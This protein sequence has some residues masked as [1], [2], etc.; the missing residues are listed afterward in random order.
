MYLK[1]TQ[2]FKA[3]YT[4]SYKYC[5]I[6]TG[7]N[8]KVLKTHELLNKILFSLSLSALF[9]VCLRFLRLPSGRVFSVLGHSTL[10]NYV[11]F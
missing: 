8:T 4:E 2:T 3:Y 9:S 7:S 6:M 5:V 10:R 1:E 11:E